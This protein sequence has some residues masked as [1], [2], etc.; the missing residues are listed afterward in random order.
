MGV[1]WAGTESLSCFN[2]VLVFIL[3][4]IEI[5]QCYGVY[6]FLGFK[7]QCW[8]EVFSYSEKEIEKGTEKEERERKKVINFEVFWI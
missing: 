3:L 2:G 8:F 6:G 4:L 7:I 1:S 5:F